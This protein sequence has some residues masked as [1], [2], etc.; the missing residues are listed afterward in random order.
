MNRAIV[1]PKLAIVRLHPVIA[2]RSVAIVP[3]ELVTAG[4]N[5]AILFPSLAIVELKRLIAGVTLVAEW[6]NLAR[7]DPIHSATIL[8]P[9]AFP[10]F[11]E[12]FPPSRPPL[13]SAI[14]R[15]CSQRPQSTYSTFVLLL[16]QN[17]KPTWPAG[18]LR[19]KSEV[20]PERPVCA[21]LGSRATSHVNRPIKGTCL[22]RF[23]VTLAPVQK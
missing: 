19:R 13:Q 6:L 3:A 16:L 5:V 4:P 15:Y 10:S 22:R 17:W 21:A 18:K 14:Y 1:L 8:L 11:A 12:N 23:F 9:P 2:G 7:S 20:S